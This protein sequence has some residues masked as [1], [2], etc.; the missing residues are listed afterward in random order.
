MPRLLGVHCA[1]SLKLLRISG[2][3]YFDK[4]VRFSRNRFVRLPLTVLS[5]HQDNFAS[6]SYLLRCFPSLSQLHLL[7]PNLFGNKTPFHEISQL[8]PFEMA[9]RVPHLT[10]LLSVLRATDVKI[11]TYSFDVDVDRKGRREIR[12]LRATPDEDLSRDCWTL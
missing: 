7:G 12:W 1:T 3:S 5:K 10:S 6:F 4:E 9:F 8:E 11:F 2:S